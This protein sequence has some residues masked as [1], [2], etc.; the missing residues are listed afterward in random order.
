MVISFLRFLYNSITA[1]FFNFWTRKNK[2]KI[3][4]YSIDALWRLG[5]VKFTENLLCYKKAEDI[6]S[7]DIINNK[8]WTS[9]LEIRPSLPITRTLFTVWESL[10]AMY[11]SPFGAKAMLCGDS[12]YTSVAKSLFSRTLALVCAGHCRDLP[13]T[14]LRRLS[15]VTLRTKWSSRICNEP[16]NGFI[17][18][19]VGHLRFTFNKNEYLLHQIVNYDKIQQLNDN[20]NSRLN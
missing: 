12:R 20:V 1:N 3:L 13:A 5:I 15:G 4:A 2:L 9:N 18:N 14:T 16:S 7:Y 17:D 6:G 8:K 10:S 11:K 19:S